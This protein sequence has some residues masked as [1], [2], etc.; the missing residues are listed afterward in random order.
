MADKLI[1]IASH[2]L[3]EGLGHDADTLEAA[4]AMLRAVPTRVQKIEAL[5]EAVEAARWGSDARD[6]IEVGWE[7]GAE[8]SAVEAANHARRSFRLLGLDAPEDA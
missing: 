8:R 2:L 3:N 4:A 1:T 6:M 7:P 5:H